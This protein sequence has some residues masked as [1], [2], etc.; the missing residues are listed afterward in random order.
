MSIECKHQHLMIM[1][2][3]WTCISSSKIVIVKSMKQLSP[4]KWTKPHVYGIQI[5]KLLIIIVLHRINMNLSLMNAIY[6]INEIYNMYKRS[7][8]TYLF[9][10]SLQSLVKALFSSLPTCL[11]RVL[12]F[13]RKFGYEWLFIHSRD[14][15]RSICQA[16]AK[17][18]R[19]LQ[20]FL[21][22]KT[23]LSRRFRQAR[24][25]TRK[26]TPDPGCRCICIIVR[27]NSELCLRRIYR[28]HDATASAKSNRERERERESYPMNYLCECT[29]F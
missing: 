18:S 4:I 24:S 20:Q 19:P 1:I 10:L 8:A 9:H 23:E 28:A 17:S 29:S 13:R 2:T 21:P 22:R 25:L 27:T 14:S 12:N 15:E 3:L 7:I 6:M 5:C 11:V 16:C 26:R